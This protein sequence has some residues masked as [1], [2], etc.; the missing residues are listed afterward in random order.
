M[1]MHGCEFSKNYVNKVKIYE[2][3]NAE[4]DFDYYICLGND[5]IFTSDASNGTWHEWNFGDGTIAEGSNNHISHQY[6]QTGYYTISHIASVRSNGIA[7]CSDTVS[8]EDAIA[9]ER[10]ISATFSLDSLMYN[11]Y[12]VCPTINTSV[13]AEPAG[14][15]LQYNWNMGN[16]NILHVQTPRH[17]YTTPGTYDINLELISRGG[18]SSTYSQT[19][20]ISGPSADIYIS[21]TIV[22]AGGTVHFAMTNAI[23]VENF[24]WVVGGGYNYYTQEVT[25]QY[26]YAPESGYFPVTLSLQNGNCNVDFTNQVY[27]YRLTTDFN[28]VDSAGNTIVDGAC[29]PLV[30]NLTYSG[31]DDVK[32]RWYI[33]GIPYSNV[34]SI[35][36]TNTSSTSDQINVISL[37]IT[38][39]IGCIDSVS[40]QYIVYRVPEIHTS[41][42]TLICKGSEAQIWASGGTSYYW[43]PPIDDSTQIQ[44]ISTDEATIYYVYTSNDK[45]CM[46]MDSVAI[47]IVQPFEA[48]I[49]QQ[50]FGIN[51]GD[52]AVAIVVADNGLECYVSPE[53]YSFA[54]NCDSIQLFPLENTNFTLVLRDTLGCYETSFDIFVGVD[55]KLS[56]DVPSAFTP[57]SVGDGNNVVYV[58]GLGIKQLRQFRIYNRWGEEVF[59]TD[60]LHTGWDGTIGGKVQ[61]QDT[62]SYYVEAEM[63]DGSIK[64]KKGNVM[65]IK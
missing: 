53:E 37:A 60:D 38:D 10:I 12:P 40:H 56:L 34:N 59:F 35:S 4:I 55:M 48:E 3:P 57:T 6:A 13:Q 17:L 52:T 54:G 62:Y 50:E 29:P 36:W 26:G 39:S 61:N 25:H 14:T 32:E 22:C 21:D 9:V 64:T 31:S 33:N 11:C 16:G 24:V 27:V 51:V 49:S 20:E 30:G 23:D 19:V 63:F 45:G 58:R 8:Y 7:V 28:L 42:D 15:Y 2:T 43:A 41:G 18:C 47:N 1:T 65:L 46:N 44:N 5:Q